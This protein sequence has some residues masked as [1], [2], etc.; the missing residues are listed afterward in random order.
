M[1]DFFLVNMILHVSIVN[2]AFEDLQENE[3]QKKASDTGNRFSL[4]DS[5]LTA[6]LSWR[7]K[8]SAVQ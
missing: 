3:V 7:R 4:F 6:C 8:S 2:P 5:R 1:F